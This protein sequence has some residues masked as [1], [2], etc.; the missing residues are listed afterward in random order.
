MA[1]QPHQYRDPAEGHSVVGLVLDADTRKPVAAAQVSS[2]ELA[3]S[4][5]SGPKGVFRAKTFSRDAVL[6][7]IKEGYF[8]ARVNLLGRDSLVVYL[9]QADKTLRT[10]R[11][12]SP[13]GVV[14]M[15]DRT[16]TAQAMDIKD[17]N[18]GYFSVSDALTGRFA[19]LRVSSKGGMVGEGSFFNLRGNRTL[20]GQNTP[21]LV[22]D[23]V[24]FISDQ[25][26]S[27]IIIHGIGIQCLCFELQTAIIIKLQCQDSADI[28]G[29]KDT[30]D[31]QFL[32]DR[33][34]KRIKILIKI[35]F[36]LIGACT[37]E[38]NIFLIHIKTPLLNM[39]LSAAT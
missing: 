1:A 3:K 7:V 12:Y 32:F 20:L 27:N 4:V 25:N 35:I 5:V 21:L 33:F 15:S 2:G 37:A 34:R 8:S 36:L 6:N 39:F 31:M 14:P 16:S 29:I 10:D 17:V 9:Q 28:F 23:G 22:V 18:R 11:Y 30:H 38:H 26:T 24:P 19:G 13:D